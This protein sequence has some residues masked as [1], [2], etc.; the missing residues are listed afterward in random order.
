[1]PA[2]PSS[3]AWLEQRW[4]FE[5]RQCGGEPALVFDTGD[6]YPGSSRTS[7]PSW[8][9]RASAAL[10]I[11]CTFRQGKPQLALKTAT[12]DFERDL[13]ARRLERLQKDCRRH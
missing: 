1:M 3:T 13:H 4:R 9:S 12:K 6:L 5:R 7:A 8:S 11:T 2:D 10:Q